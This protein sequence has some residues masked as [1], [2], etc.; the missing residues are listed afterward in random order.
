MNEQADRG[1][2]DPPA[3]SLPISADMRAVIIADAAMDTR[4]IGEKRRE[5]VRKTALEQLRRAVTVASGVEASAADS[6]SQ[7]EE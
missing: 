2:Y 3:P 1:F 5:H 6:R 4:F 7:L